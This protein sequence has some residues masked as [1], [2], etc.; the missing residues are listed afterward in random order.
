MIDGEY[1]AIPQL[2]GAMEIGAV[3]AT[4]DTA[5]EAID[6]CK[7]I[8]KLVEG[9]SIEKP[10]D[11]MD[12][13]LVDLKKILSASASAPASKEQRAAEEAMKSGKISRKQ[14]DKLAS[15]HEWA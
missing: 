1:Y 15:K 3:V 10:V 6:E 12:E 11:S 4:G 9:Y 13:A 5:A 7:R 2:Q 8:A 14:Y